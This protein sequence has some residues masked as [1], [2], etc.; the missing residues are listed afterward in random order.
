M[1][2]LAATDIYASRSID[3]CNKKIFVPRPHF[4]ANGKNAKKCK[5]IAPSGPG[6]DSKSDPKLAIG[7]ADP[8]GRLDTRRRRA[9]RHR[10]RAEA[11]NCGHNEE[12]GNEVWNIEWMAV[13]HRG[14]GGKAIK[15]GLCARA[16]RRRQAKGGQAPAHPLEGASRPRSAQVGAARQ[17]G[18]QIITVTVCGTCERKSLAQIRLGANLGGSGQG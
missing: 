10:R 3:P 2:T 4:R 17:S 1:K 11:L 18:R 13:A 12:R 5:K 16:V 6:S 7:S 15:C 8:K 14:R 9:Q